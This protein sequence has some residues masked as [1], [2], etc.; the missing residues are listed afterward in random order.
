MKIQKPT[1][2]RVVFF[3]SARGQGDDASEVDEYAG[4]ITRVDEANP[5]IVDIKTF[6]KNSTDVA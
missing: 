4:M 3:T 2:G 6:G 1:K 5:S